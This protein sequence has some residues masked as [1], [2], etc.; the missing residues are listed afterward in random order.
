MPTAEQVHEEG[1]GFRDDINLIRE[2]PPSQPA[3][4]PEEA[5]AQPTTYSWWQPEYYR[6]LFDVDT[7]EVLNR[8]RKSL[9]PW[10]PN[11]VEIARQNPDLYGPFWITSTVVFLMAAAGNINSYVNYVEDSKDN[12]MW[13]YDINYV[14]FSAFAI[15]GYNFLLPVILWGACKCLDIPIQLMDCVCIYG[16]ALFVYIPITM[17]AIIPFD[18]VRWML[19]GIA[20]TI[21]SLF[22]AGNL[23]MELKSSAKY[24]LILTAVVV[25]LNIGLALTFKLYF[26]HLVDAPKEKPTTAPP[27]TT[28]PP[29]T[30]AAANASL[31]R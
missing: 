6:Y 12:N 22:L 11:F 27:T 1:S 24:G 19:V 26:F 18:W 30:A 3:V 4:E 21:S 14:S 15:Y 20:A 2:K 31:Q 9:I 29:T 25:A 28:P 5:A 7:S 8:L 16:Y 13:H 10:P 23:F 17:L